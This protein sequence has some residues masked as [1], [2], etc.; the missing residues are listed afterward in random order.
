MC[1]AL[2]T[3]ETNAYDEQYKFSNL[4]NILINFNGMHRTY[5]INWQD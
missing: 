2:K 5:V 1:S 3:I 4:K